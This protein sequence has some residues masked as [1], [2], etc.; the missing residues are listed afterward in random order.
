MTHPTRRRWIQG[1]T[2]TLG[3]AAV[4]PQLFAQ[5]GPVKIGYAIARTGPLIAFANHGGQ[6]H[7]L[8]DVFGGFT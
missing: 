1:A 5:G 4:A 6:T 8:V 2:T 3:A 7:L